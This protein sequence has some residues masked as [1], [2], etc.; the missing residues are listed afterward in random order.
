MAGDDQLVYSISVYFW[1]LRRV[2]LSPS[3]LRAGYFLD[4]ELLFFP[5]VKYQQDDKN[6]IL[7]LVSEIL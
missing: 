4:R 1:H 6:S 7:F 2:T 5:L 3:L